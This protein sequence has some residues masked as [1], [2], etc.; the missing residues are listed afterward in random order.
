MCEGGGVALAG[1]HER[2]WRLHPLPGAQRPA[3]LSRGIGAAATRPAHLKLRVAL[4]LPPQ[5]ALADEK[6]GQGHGYKR[7]TRGK[8]DWAWDSRDNTVVKKYSAHR[9]EKDKE[10]DALECAASSEDGSCSHAALHARERSWSAS[11][12]LRRG[13]RPSPRPHTPPPSP[14]PAATLP[15]LLPRGRWLVLV[16]LCKKDEDPP[17]TRHVKRA[18]LGASD[19]ATLAASE[20]GDI[21]LPAAL[22]A[23]EE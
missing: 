7:R 5:K 8:D 15:P 19:L 11:A 20:D 3:L 22:Y 1:H 17:V 2:L 21:C 18:R 14:P 6:K 4:F 16:K 23:W 13:R 12:A 9:D 10:N